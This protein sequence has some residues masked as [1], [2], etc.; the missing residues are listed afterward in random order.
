MEQ[1]FT[2]NSFKTEDGCLAIDTAEVIAFAVKRTGTAAER[3]GFERFSIIVDDQRF[4]TNSKKVLDKE[5][6]NIAPGSRCRAFR[7]GGKGVT[8]NFD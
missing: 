7:N 8:I 3:Q 6:Q 5:L 4:S 2:L 1:F